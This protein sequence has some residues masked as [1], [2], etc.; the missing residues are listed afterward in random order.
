M[1]ALDHFK[2]NNLNLT[3]IQSRPNKTCKGKKSMNFQADFIAKSDEPS[4]AV[5]IAQLK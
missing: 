2:K 4:V 3:R 5:L 1:E